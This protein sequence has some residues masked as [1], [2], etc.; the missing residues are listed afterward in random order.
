MMSGM[1]A[2]RWFTKNKKI[3]ILA[4]FVCLAV[5]FL[6]NGFKGEMEVTSV[7]RRYDAY[8]FP[9][10][11][12]YQTNKGL[13]RYRGDLKF[14]PDSVKKENNIY[15]GEYSGIVEKDGYSFLNN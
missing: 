5:L 12:T 2:M 4:A 10:Y 9:E 1:Q 8:S 11:I 6:F 3:L 13:V 14:N 7:K 15:Y